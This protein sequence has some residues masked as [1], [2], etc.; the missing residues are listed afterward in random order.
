[1]PFNTSTIIRYLLFILLIKNHAIG[2]LNFDLRSEY[3]V[4]TILVNVRSHHENSCSPYSVWVQD[5]CHFKCILSNV[6]KTRRT[7]FERVSKKN[8][9]NSKRII[10]SNFKGAPVR[11]LT[12]NTLLY[13]VKN[14]EE[15]PR[16]WKKLNEWIKNNECNKN[17]TQWHIEMKKRR[18]YVKQYQC[19]CN[20]PQPI[21]HM[22]SDKCCAW[23]TFHYLWARWKNNEKKY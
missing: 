18:I 12:V 2:T 9:F 19:E 5:V 4:V 3:C 11:R 23:K 1:M 6:N 7:R 21:E 16:I 13:S 17:N 14:F 10:I 20:A 22:H 15:S 8:H